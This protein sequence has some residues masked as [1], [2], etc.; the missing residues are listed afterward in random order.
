M[1]LCLVVLL[2]IKLKNNST[3][4]LHTS[5]NKEI[6]I[7]ASIISAETVGRNDATVTGPLLIEKNNLY[8]KKPRPLGY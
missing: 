8:E 2:F 7:V 3:N 6:N 4:Q 1:I 5:N